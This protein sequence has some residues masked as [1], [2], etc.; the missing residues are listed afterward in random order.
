LILG[1]RGRRT[2]KGV[3]VQVVKGGVVE[4]VRS[5]T[6]ANYGRSLKS[7]PGAWPKVKKR[8]AL[9]ELTNCWMW[10]GLTWRG[11]GT[12]QDNAQA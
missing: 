1:S 6:A 5:L 7:C 4:N 3:V 10:P 9:K 12:P 11:L 2:F 8:V